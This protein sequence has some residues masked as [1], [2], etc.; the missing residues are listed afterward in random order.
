M[1]AASVRPSGEIATDRTSASVASIVAARPRDGV[2]PKFPSRP[3]LPLPRLQIAELLLEEAE[4]ATG[5]PSTDLRREAQEHLDFATG[6]FRNMKMQP[7]LERALR[8][9]GLLKA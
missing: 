9:K 8:H 2:R 6:E 7:S 1:P 4:D 5:E 3:E